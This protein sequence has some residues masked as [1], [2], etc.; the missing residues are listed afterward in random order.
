MSAR[1]LLIDDDIELTRLLAELLTSEGFAIDTLAT[2][3]GALTFLTS[4]Q[5]P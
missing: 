2:G 3:A 5:R 1:L 4:A